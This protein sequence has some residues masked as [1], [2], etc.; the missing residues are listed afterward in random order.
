MNLFYRDEKEAYLHQ[1][2]GS[3]ENLKPL[4]MNLFK[5]PLLVMALLSSA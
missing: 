3:A 5:Q 4:L 2:S 1:L